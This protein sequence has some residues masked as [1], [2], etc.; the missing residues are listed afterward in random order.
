MA[1]ISNSGSASM[2]AVGRPDMP[3]LT[4]PRMPLATGR[5]AAAMSGASH[6]LC[7]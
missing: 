4:A 2:T 7:K 5:R 1:Q 3:W 6:T